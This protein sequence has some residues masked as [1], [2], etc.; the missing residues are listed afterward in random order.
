MYARIYADIAK[1][2]KKKRF[3]IYDLISGNEA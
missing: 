3:K 1:Q 2:E